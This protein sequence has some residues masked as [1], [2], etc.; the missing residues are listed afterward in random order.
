MSRMMELQGA[1]WM[2]TR[3]QTYSGLGGEEEPRSF[4][5][6]AQQFE[7][8]QLL[9]NWKSPDHQYFKVRVN[10]VEFFVLRHHGVGDEW[11]ATQLMLH[12]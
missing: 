1:R 9:D 4:D 10:G 3:A 11:E 6:G 7:V 5:F 12:H 2:N 8:L